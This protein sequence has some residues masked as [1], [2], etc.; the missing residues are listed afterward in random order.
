MN[1]T[2]SLSCT[3]VLGWCFGVTAFSVLIAAIIF[4]MFARGGHPPP[5]K[6]MCIC[7]MKQIGTA[8]NL[9]ACDWDDTLPPLHTTAQ[10]APEGK[11]WTDKILV[12]A[13]NKKI[14]QCPAHPERLVY[15]F[16]RKLSGMRERDIKT[17]TADLALVWDS[18]SDTAWN[19]NLND[20]KVFWPA[21]GRTPTPG[22]YI[23]W[24]EKAD[25]AS[26]AWPEWSL[27]NHEDVNIVCFADGHVKPCHYYSSYS[28]CGLPIFSPK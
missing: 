17:N 3:Q 12:Y 2:S 10:R 24:T 27:P 5:K 6:T 9:Y 26:K 25:S 15:S 22:C 7:N 19:N 1:R 18:V 20:D 14:I 16:N 21:K 8:F 13:K 28:D 11:A 23:V 4:P